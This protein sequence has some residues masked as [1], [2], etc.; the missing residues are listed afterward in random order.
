MPHLSAAA[1]LIGKIS[2]YLDVFTESWQF[3]AK[4]FLESCLHGHELR[5]P[6]SH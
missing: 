5:S 3:N 4:G 6:K 2:R 1:F